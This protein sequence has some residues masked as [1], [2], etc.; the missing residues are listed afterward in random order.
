MGCTVQTW[1]G[2]C[3]QMTGQEWPIL[4]SLAKHAEDVGHCWRALPTP[5]RTDT[6]IALQL[7][8]SVPGRVGIWLCRL[9]LIDV[10]GLWIWLTLPYQIWGIYHVSHTRNPTFHKAH[11]SQLINDLALCKT[12]QKGNPLFHTVHILDSLL[13]INVLC[14]LQ[15]LK[16]VTE[17]TPFPIYSFC[18]EE[19]CIV[20]F[21]CIIHFIL[22]TLGV[23]F[24][25]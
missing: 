25:L 6:G 20:H 21:I 12:P 15:S 13:C 4:G 7:V 17:L 10:Q 23:W 8:L 11:I 19:V 18:S 2:V 16:A 5:L 22:S 24:K 14:N 9:D 1:C 3:L